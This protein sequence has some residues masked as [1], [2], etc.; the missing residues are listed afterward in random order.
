MKKTN[1]KPQFA[2]AKTGK[3]LE[4]LIYEE[5]GID[6]WTG[7]GLT[8]IDVAAAIK[9]A[10]EF[11]DIIVRLNSPGGNC[12]DGVTIYNLLLS[13]KKPIEVYVDGYA[14]S[15]ASTIAMVGDKIHMSQGAM[16]MVHNAAWGI[17][18]DARAL[19]KAADDIE[20]IS[21]TVGEIYVA[22]T[23]RTPEEIKGIMDAETWMGG[24]EAVRL[25][26]ANDVITLDAQRA[27][28]AKALAAQFSLKGFRNVP[29]AL[30]QD[31]AIQ[32]TTADC[33]CDCGPCMDGDCADCE[34]D[35]CTSP[36]CTCPNHEE[37]SL[38]NMPSLEIYER[39]AALRERMA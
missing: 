20:N 23:K 22:R 1:I 17:F 25:G 31:V 14:A 16:L 24:E 15:A 3:T 18:G 36:G 19:R 37:M 28:R 38:E 4:I 29:D 10:G 35:P 30:K 32:K 6:F 39:R 13:L 9:A 26:F 21:V 33:E 8:P 2:A 34:M 12:F 7:E 11:D 5:I 27:G